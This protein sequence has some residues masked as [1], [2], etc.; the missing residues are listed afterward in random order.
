MPTPPRDDNGN[1]DLADLPEVRAEELAYQAREVQELLKKPAVVAAFAAT[2]NRIK[3]EWKRA[4]T[5]AEREFCWAQIK[6]LEK[7]RTTVRGWA[8]HASRLT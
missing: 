8:D 2:E 1:V 4:A 7:W 6:G 3:E 5:T